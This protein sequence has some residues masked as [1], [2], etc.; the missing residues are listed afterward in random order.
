LSGIG[1]GNLLEGTMD[2]N[3]RQALEEALR[4]RRALAAIITEILDRFGVDEG[5]LA[6]SSRERLPLR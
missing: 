2:A 1:F 5:R 4:P 3:W 6:V